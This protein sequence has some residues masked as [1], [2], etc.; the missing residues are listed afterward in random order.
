M[1]M[2]SRIERIFLVRIGTFQLKIS[3]LSFK[4]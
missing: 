2:I 4:S 1:L 3:F